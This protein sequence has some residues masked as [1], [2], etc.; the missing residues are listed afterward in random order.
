MVI[1]LGGELA[2]PDASQIGKEDVIAANPD[3][4]FVVYMPYSGD[5]KEQVKQEKLDVILKDKTYASLDAVKNGRVV[6]IMLSE[7]YASATRT[8]D[9]IITFAEGLYPEIDLKLR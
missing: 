4:I 3:V 9:G 6:P 2:N 5:D 8:K 1:K 7:M